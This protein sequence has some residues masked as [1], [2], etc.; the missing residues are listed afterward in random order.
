MLKDGIAVA[1]TY[2]GIFRS[3]GNGVVLTESD[4]GLTGGIVYSLLSNGPSVY[5]G[6]SDGIFTVNNSGDGWERLNGTLLNAQILIR[7]DDYLF[8]GS[9][10]RPMT[11]S[12]I[13]QVAQ[14]V[15]EEIEPQQC[16]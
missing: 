4:S 14:S 10:I 8:A 3:S 1:G 5:A 11:Q 12:R 2:Q 9:L 15:A 7:K 16:E 6:T 13:H